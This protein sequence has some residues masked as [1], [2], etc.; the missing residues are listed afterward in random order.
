ME[1]VL[2]FDYTLRTVAL[3][4]AILGA[5]SGT[6]GAFAVLRGQSLLGDAVSHAALP[7]VALA[8]L[9]TGLKTPLVLLLGAAVTG[10]LGTM[11]VSAVS[12]A[13]RVRYDSA[14]ATMLATFFGFGL[15]LL[16]YI[17][18]QPDAQQAG[19]DKFLFGQ[20]AALVMA[21]VH[22]MALFGLAAVAALALGWKEFKLLTF[23]AEFA[24]SI[25]LPVRRLEV[26]L[27]TL[28][29]AAIVTGLQTVGVVLMSALVVAPGVAARQWTNRLGVMIWLSALVGAVS[30]V[31]GAV[32]SALRPQ[33]PTGPTIVLC[34][35]VLVVFSLLFA[36]GRGLVARL[37]RRGQLQLPQE[38]KA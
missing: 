30:G 16:T 27:M 28:L 31:T 34:A 19:L 3:G 23:D 11:A 29:V 5:V 13:S 4:A 36:P 22:A 14:L 38:E 2:S 26:A 33:L 8:F 37:R 15:V 1:I 20:A 10:W 9:L 7:G 18:K 6:L 17:Q 12:R 24:A 35:T 21:D 32:I 25:G